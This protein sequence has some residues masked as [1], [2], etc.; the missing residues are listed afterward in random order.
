MAICR[1]RAASE[2]QPLWESLAEQYDVSLVGG[3]LMPVPLMV[4][5]EGG[6]HSDAGLSFQECMIVPH[7]FKSFSD[8]LRAGVETF[9]A[10]K[11]LLKEAG[12]VT[13]VGD[14]GAFAPRVETSDEAFSFIVKAIEKAGYAGRIKMAL[15]A[16]ASEFFKAGE[17][18]VDGKTLSREQ[19]AEYYE[20]MID[21]YPLVSIEDSHGEDD[22]EGFMLMKKNLGKRL[23]L[24]G[25]DFLVTN[26]KRIQEAITK[27]AA[28]A[29]LIKVNQIGTV[30][31]TVDAIEMTRKAG[32]QP[33][34][35]HRGGDTEDAFIAHLAVALKTGQIK[36]GAPSR[37][38]RTAKYNELL[39]IE[40]EL[41]PRAIFESPFRA[42]TI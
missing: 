23:Q 3:V 36:T 35:S 30:S 5:I 38:E 41:G 20:R 9:H 2:K 21:R 24:V 27:D 42:S 22:W 16:A 28:N 25:D 39:R 18:H 32:W 31:E 26:T 33:I 29:V 37:G 13:A 17:Y 1:A 6:A 40:E 34:V 8:A 11:A 14:E 15:D 12:Q 10:L 4:I 7:D 19:L